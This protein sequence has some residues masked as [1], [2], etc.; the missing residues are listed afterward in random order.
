MSSFVTEKKNFY[1][2]EEEKG[3]YTMPF[4]RSIPLYKNIVC[5]IIMPNMN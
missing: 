3:K 2:V 4:I 5:K 1:Q